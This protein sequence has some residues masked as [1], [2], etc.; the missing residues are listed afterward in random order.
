[1]V[2]PPPFRT[3]GK[4][5]EVAGRES[6]RISE[7]SEADIRAI[8]EAKP[9]GSSVSFEIP[10][11]PVA[12][13]R[14]RLT[15]RGGFARAYTPK[16]TASFEARVAL[17]AQQAMAGAEPIE[18][19][20]KLTI[21]VLLPIPQSWSKKKQ[22]M[23]ANRDILPCSRPDLDNYLKAVCDGSNEIVW[24]DDSQVV[25][26]DASKVYSTVPGIAVTVE[27]IAA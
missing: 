14:P 15:T 20:V 18:G 12:K 24:R 7:L 5:K 17:A 26:V 4:L 11:A 27:R 21:F 22:E 10:G 23:A 6:K 25:R 16:K 1:M 19:P 13:G 3:S 8:E 2:T 9:R